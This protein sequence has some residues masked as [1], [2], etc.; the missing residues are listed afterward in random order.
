MTITAAEVSFLRLLGQLSH[1]EPRNGWTLGMLPEL[2]PADYA[3]IFAAEPDAI[4]D[5]VSECGEVLRAAYSDEADMGLIV[6]QAMQSAARV[7]LLRELICFC[8]RARADGAGSSAWER[9]VAAET[10]ISTTGS[11]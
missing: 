7:V 4:D 3:V 2:S 9:T 8:E 10:G 5:A 11:L 6:K 1:D